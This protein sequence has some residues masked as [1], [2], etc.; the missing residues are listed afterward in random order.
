MAST[1]TLPLT[2]NTQASQERSDTPRP[3]VLITRQLL[4]EVLDL[5]SETAELEVWP[6]EH[7]PGPDRLKE[8]L[9]DKEGVLTNI[10]DRIDADVM[11]AAP[12]LKVISQ[13]GVG[14]D[15]ID[16]SE[17]TRRGILVGNTPGVLAKATADLAFALLMCAARRVSE[18]DRWMRSGHGELAFHP[19]YWLGIDIHG[20]TIG[21]I[22]L[23]E[24]GLEMAQRARA[25]T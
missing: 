12:S 20:S 23:G 24:I 6:D 8:L 14:V 5:I 7:P 3:H 1:R 16:V 25:L 11:G 17:A 2:D 22:G 19:Q 9:S 18:S 13:L 4:P 21:I 15:N 10:I